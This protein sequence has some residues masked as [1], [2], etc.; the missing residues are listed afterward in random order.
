MLNALLAM[1]DVYLDAEF[2]V[3]VFSEVLC[4]IDTAVLAARA[5]EA[6]LQVGE[7][8]LDVAC[9]MTVAQ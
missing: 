1:D 2:R 5:S 6:E 8:A 4:G 9:H 7:A 3:Q